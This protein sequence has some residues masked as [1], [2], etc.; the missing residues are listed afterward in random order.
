MRILI[1]HQ[2]FPGQFRQLAP[3]LQQCGHEVVAICSH[4]RSTGINCRTLRYKEPSKHDGLPLS[5]ELAHDSFQRASEVAKLCGQLD[6]EGW[7]PERICAHSGWGETLAIREVWDDV[8]QILWPELWVSPEHG[9]HG[10]DP[11]K[12][13]PGL[14][15]R[16]DQVGRNSLTRAALDQ[17]VSW[18]LPTQHQANS[19][20]NEF[21]DSRMHVIHEGIDTKLACPNPDVNFTVRGIQ[22]NRSIPTITFINRSLERL[23]GF[24]TFMRSLPAI[25][26]SYPKV[27]ILIVGDDQKGYGT[28]H[29]TGRPLREVMLEELSGKI[30]LE[31]IHFLGRIPYLQFLAILQASWVH[32]YLSYPFVLGWSCL[33]AMSC[34]CCIVGSKNMPVEEVIHNGIEGLLVPITSPDDVSRAVIKMLGDARIRDELGRNARKNVLNLDQSLLLPKTLELIQNSF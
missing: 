24:D 14:E 12:A 31:R 29:E 26:R 16:L 28:L 25:Q 21:R 27:S 2:N 22:I 9:G 13:P 5:S 18:V 4:E 19:F 15:L 23:R 33:E 7:R 34:G 3:Y 1:I 30:D 17:A 10:F 6:A 11:Q 20:P 32:I 8:P